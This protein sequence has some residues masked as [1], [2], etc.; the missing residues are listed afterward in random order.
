MCIFHL[1]IVLQYEKRLQ[2]ACIH[3]ICKINDTPPKG[4]SLFYKVRPWRVYNTEATAISP[5]YISVTVW[6]T[7]NL[8]WTTQRKGNSIPKILRL[9]IWRQVQPLSAYSEPVS[10]VCLSCQSHSFLHCFHIFL[11]LITSPLFPFHTK[12]PESPIFRSKF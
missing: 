4:P 11:H 8:S 12:H 2:A 7:V 9:N 5:L 10:L 6:S 1:Y 3:R